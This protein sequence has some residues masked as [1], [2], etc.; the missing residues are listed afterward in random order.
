MACLPF[1]AIKGGAPVF[2]MI[3]EQALNKRPAPTPARAPRYTNPAPRYIRTV[4][5]GNRTA[6]RYIRTVYRYSR[7]AYRGN[8]TVYRYIASLHRGTASLYYRYRATAYQSCKRELPKAL[9][10]DL[11]FKGSWGAQPDGNIAVRIISP[12][13]RR[14]AKCSTRAS[15]KQPWAKLIQCAAPGSAPREA[16]VLYPSLRRSFTKR[17]APIDGRSGR[18]PTMHGGISG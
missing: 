8:R 13:G 6:P 5:R 9:A 7:T 18:I 15:C 3:L 16:R 17:P 2:K 14:S 12:H 11:R 4:H 10:V 1:V